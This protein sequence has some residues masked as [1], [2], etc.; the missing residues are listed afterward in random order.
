VRLVLGIAVVLALASVG[1]LLASINQSSAKDMNSC[2]CVA[3]R[4]DDVQDYYLRDVQIGV[5]DE[6]SKRDV[7]LTLG[8]IGNYFGNDEGL[9][10]YVKNGATAG[11]LEVANHGWNH[12]SFIEYRKDEQSRLLNQTNS[13]M[14][15]ILGIKPLVFIAPYNTVNAD[16][17]AAARENN[18]RYISANMTMDRPPYH[19]RDGLYHYPSAAITGDLNDDDT[20]WVGF[21]H[22]TTLAQ[23]KQSVRDHGFAVVTMH[24]ME[25][26]ER[27]GLEYFNRI[28]E[29][30]IGELD[31]LLS[32]LQIEG[33]EIV[34]VGEL[35][36]SAA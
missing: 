6:F 2:R 33:Y 34:A 13:K 25:F 21:D 20:S 7:K 10:T 5:M 14:E 4:F 24:P 9:V 30:Q 22:Q 11:R 12:E 29:K 8:V 27:S 18:I 28:D 36:R 16:T 17:F 1:A 35:D 19:E 23:I 32:S 15:A 31:A 3:F 26:A